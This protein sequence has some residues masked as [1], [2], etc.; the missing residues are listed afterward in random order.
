[1]KKTIIACTVA[2]ALS[3]CSASGTSPIQPTN[4][5]NIP[6]NILQFKVGTANLAGASTGLN[7]V[8]TYRQPAGG[9]HPGD[10][11]TL[12][13]SPTLTLPHGQTL[14]GPAA[15]PQAGFG[16][17]FD[18]ISSAFVAPAQAEVAGNS[19]QST[20]QAVGAKNITTFG[21]SGGVFGIG[22][23]PYNYIGS[24]D[25]QNAPTNI[26]TPFSVA[27]YPVP[28]YNNNMPAANPN[29]F[30]PWGGPPAFDLS[31]N[32]QSVVGSPT[33]P[34]GT[35]GIG[36]GIDVFALGSGLNPPPGG[37]YNLSV[38]VAGSSGFTTK[39]ASASMHTHPLVLPLAATPLFVGD[40]SGGGTFSV[41]MPGGTEEAY[42]QVTDFGP[43]ANKGGCNGA[44]FP[45][46]SGSVQIYYT[47]LTKNSGTVNLPDHAGPNGS[48]SLCQGDVF[49]VQ[50]IAFDYP[51]YE[52]SYPA[53]YGNPHPSLQGLHGNTD[54]L[55][56]SAAGCS[57]VTPGGA[58]LACSAIVN[59]SGKPAPVTL[60]IGGGQPAVRHAGGRPVFNKI[61]R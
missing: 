24:Y 61:H 12:I 27:P 18:P 17:G 38:G 33:E 3:A 14:P 32:G 6:G 19:I 51:A 49:T 36:E 2:V 58:P 50:L 31:G 45:S 48:Q 34:G 52:A 11:G 21:Q 9:F 59:S 22:I 15:N 5:A 40:G 20:S 56:I 10:S 26:N 4:P 47:I 8:T 54:N 39:S 29:I 42:V 13:N 23:E 7:V 16:Q 43:P 25:D 37:T 41:T 53:S 60:P 1:M 55:T 57:Q 35:A 30:L 28:L 46:S 44:V